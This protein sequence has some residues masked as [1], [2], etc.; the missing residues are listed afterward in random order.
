M[1]L[2]LIMMIDFVAWA[3]GGLASMSNAYLPEQVP[4]TFTPSTTGQGQSSHE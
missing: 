4:L 3:R 2:I 1:S